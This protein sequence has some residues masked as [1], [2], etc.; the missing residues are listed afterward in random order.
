MRTS[1]SKMSITDFLNLL[2]YNRK[3]FEI[4]EQV[5]RLPPEGE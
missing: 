5:A 4:I 3:R 1:F 2:V